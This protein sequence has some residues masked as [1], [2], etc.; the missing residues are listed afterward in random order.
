MADIG[1]LVEF[2]DPMEALLEA[3]IWHDAIAAQEPAEGDPRLAELA[4]VIE[5]LE[6]RLRPPP[7][8]PAPAVI[9]FREAVGRLAD[10]LKAGD[11]AAARKSRSVAETLL[12]GHPDLLAP[13]RPRF[14]ALKRRLE[15]EEKFGAAAGR[16]EDLLEK[17]D[18]LQASG[19][20]TEAVEA[21]CEA[22]FLALTT[23]LTDAE[24][25]TL[26]AK[27]RQLAPKLRLARGRRAVRD[28]QRGAAVGDRQTRDR[29]VRRALTLLPGLPESQAVPLLKQ[30]EP[31]VEQARNSSQDGAESGA[32]TTEISREIEVRDCYEAVWEYYAVADCEKLLA[33]CRR[34]QGLMAEGEPN[35]AAKC[36]R[37]EELLLDA[38]DYATPEHL[39]PGSGS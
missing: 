32:K 20:V 35:L 31:W 3:R 26:D 18:R 34:L 1:K 38:L 12:L 22:R 19:Q 29:E 11:L 15:Q 36:R 25:A 4:K 17:A 14:A 5:M 33:A 21:E 39:G 16:I 10:S 28:A 23:P 30:I 13:Y 7:D 27:Q 2:A 8:P 37:S 9:E 6:A 24:A